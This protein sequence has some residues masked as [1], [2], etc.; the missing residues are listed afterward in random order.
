MSTKNLKAT[1]I[2]V[3]SILITL[4]PINIYKSIYTRIGSKQIHFF[5]D[6]LERTQFLDPKASPTIEVLSPNHSA[7]GG[8]EFTLQVQGQGFITDTMV[9]WNTFIRPTTFISTTLVQ[10]T[11]YGSDIL[12]PGVVQVS[13]INPPPDGGESNKLPFTIESNFTYLPVLNFL[14]IPFI[15]SL[16]NIDNS[17]Q[18]NNYWVSWSPTKFTTGYVLQEATKPDFSNAVNVYSGFDLY[19]Y[20]PYPGK[21]PGTYYYRVQSYNNYASSEW[22]ATR[23][24]TVISPPAPSLFSIDNSDQNNTYT[25][26]WSDS[27]YAQGY[28]LQ[29]A[30]DPGFTNATQVYK[31]T[32]L[33]WLV[34]SPGKYPGTYYY[35]VQGYDYFGLGDWSAPSS[36]TIYPLFVGLNLRWDG[37]G[38]IRGDDYYDIGAHETFIF[39]ALTE[40]DTI[41]YN[42]H[43][44]YNPDPIGFEDEFWITYYSVSTGDWKGSTAPDDPD[45]KWSPYWFLPY[46]LKLSN[47]IT[48][49]VDNQPFTV[50]GPHTGVTSWGRTIQYWQFVNQQKFLIY[51]DGAGAKQYV[52]KGEAILRFDAGSSR[53]RLYDDIKRYLYVQ[54]YTFTVQYIMTLTQATSIPGS[55]ALVKLPQ[56]GSGDQID[57]T[58]MSQDPQMGLYLPCR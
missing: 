25:V 53:L 7:S 19:W 56:S 55:P 48:V 15:P 28:I 22:S 1:V 52:N 33:S 10:A 3:A 4:L 41:R 18:N 6:A 32:E 42:G 2:F 34:P 31:G 8:P 35:R 36:V 39:D 49:R 38:Y 45:W 44:W 37:N 17:S 43:Q 14:P 46:N 29:E 11:I 21:G 27:S 57:P 24:V 9:S 30:T 40:P 51:D 20:T 12:N 23:S 54:G 50:T 5:V 13:A 26:S 47:N 16:N 58:P